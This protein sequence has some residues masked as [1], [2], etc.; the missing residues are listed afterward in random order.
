MKSK[1]ESRTIASARI[2]VENT[3][4]WIKEFKIF[5]NCLFNRINKRVIDDMVITVCAICNLRTRLINN[6][7]TFI[8]YISS[9]LLIISGPNV[10]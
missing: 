1:L 2:K 4:R 6:M 8:I 7:K 5:T 3:I 9:I 10:V